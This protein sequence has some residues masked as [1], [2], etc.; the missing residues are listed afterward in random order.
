MTA[1]PPGP[2]A[3]RSPLI[4]AARAAWLADPARPPMASLSDAADRRVRHLIDGFVH[5]AGPPPARYAWIALGS[6]ARRELH[7]ASDQD[8]AL[9]W[10]DARAARTSYAADLAATV[11]AGLADFGMRRCAGGYMAD[12]WS[13]ALDHWIGLLHERIDAPTPQAVVDTD[14]FL[15]LRPIAGDLDVGPAAAVLLGGADSARLM[16]GLAVAATSF[17]VPR[18]AFGRR[19]HH[20]VDLKRTGL[21]PIVLLARLYGLRART[22]RVGTGDRLAAAAQSGVLSSDLCQRLTGAFTVLSRLRLARQLA[23]IDQGR[24]LSDS[25]VVADLDDDERAALRTAWQAVKA[26]QSVTDLAFRTDL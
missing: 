12:R 24:P 10:G 1:T 9:V 22:T 8:H 23:Q 19:R 15:D 18:H 6:H 13:F 7:C 25:I 11:I 14:V 20:E 26:A 5:E 21:A 4:E 17:P 2:A 16:H 3:P